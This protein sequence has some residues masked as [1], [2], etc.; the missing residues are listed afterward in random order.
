MTLTDR[1]ER[2]L[3]ACVEKGQNS[4]LSVHAL[5][6][7]HKVPYTTLQ[8]A[9]KSAPTASAVLAASAGCGRKKR[10]DDHDENIIA[11]TIIEFQANGT[12]L[13]RSCV[14]DLV[15]VYVRSLSGDR[16]AACAFHNDRPGK[17]WLLNFLKR[18]PN[19]HI[20]SSVNLKYQRAEAMCPE[21]V[22]AHFARIRALCSKHRITDA[23]QVFNL[24]ESG[25]SLRGMTHGSRSKRIV[26]RGSRPNSREV[27]WKGKCDHLTMMAVVNAAGQTFT[28]LFVLP[29]IKA[30]YRRRTDGRYETPA[31]FLPGPNYVY[32]RETAGVDSNIFLSWAENFVLETAYMRRNNRKLLL[33]YDGYAGH[34]QYRVLQLLKTNN[35]IVAG[36]PAHSS[37]VLQP[38]DVGVFAP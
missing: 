15:Q 3:A 28:P 38:L 25:F 30:R 33:V 26:K 31:D 36:L 7:K 2:I 1:Q 37:H 27:K 10:L 21:N 20:K 12:P 8:R 29:G 34:L 24:D 22:A 16:R 18:H 32:M 35:I 19:L 23:Y 6:I 9:V 17:K 14:M 5:S 11:D 4:G 13:S